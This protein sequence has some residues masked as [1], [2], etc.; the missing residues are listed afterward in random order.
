MYFFQQF[1]SFPI[2]VGCILFKLSISNIG[3]AFPYWWNVL[4]DIPGCHL[5]LK[6]SVGKGN[7]PQ[8]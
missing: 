1:F 7:D 2:W 6:I 3:N 5:R 4:A 8:P